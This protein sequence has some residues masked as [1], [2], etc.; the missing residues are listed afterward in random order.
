MNLLF[1]CTA[2]FPSE[3]GRT[4]MFAPVAEQPPANR[5]LAPPVGQ[6]GAIAL[7][8]ERW[9]DPPFVVGGRYAVTLEPA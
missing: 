2:S 8:F 7:H 6:G 5:G 1:L 3:Q 9:I 4:I